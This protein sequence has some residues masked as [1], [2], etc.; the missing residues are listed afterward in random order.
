MSSP[1][2]YE[3]R[4][5]VAL[6]HDFGVRS[7]LRSLIDALDRAYASLAAPGT[8][9]DWYDIT[10]VGN[11][12]YRVTF[13]GN[14]VAD[15]VSAGKAAAWLQWDANHLAAASVTGVVLHAAAAEG[16][17]GAVVIPGT[18]G[19][20][21]TTIVAH[22]VAA[23]YGYL[24]DE[25]VVLDGSG[26]IAPYPKPLSLDLRS[27]E[28]VG[29]DPSSL[30]LVPDDPTEKWLVPP[31]SLRPGCIAF[32]CRPRL[33]VVPERTAGPDVIVEPISKA[34]ALVVLHDHVAHPE[35]GSRTV[36]ENL[37]NFSGDIRTFRIS[38]PTSSAVASE[39]RGLM[40]EISPRKV[41]ND[42][43]AP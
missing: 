3:T 11:D 41:A 28:S 23:G 24:T 32:P 26:E 2:I 14:L 15:A 8:P 13:N 9:T 22:L 29:I 10:P 36:V 40:E 34:A 4:R 7:P 38:G 20:G 30:P 12:L 37:A 31:E 21:K 33:V 5:I 19:A 35:A 6:G 39:I 27:I 25:A 17:G 18:S 43:R 42:W 16:P 1:R